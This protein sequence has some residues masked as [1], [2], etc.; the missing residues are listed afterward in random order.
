MDF[1]NSRAFRA[2]IAENL[3]RPPTFKIAATPDTGAT[4]LRKFQRTIHPRTACPLRRTHI[5]IGMIIE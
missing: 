2:T 5:P 3:V 4:D 1:K